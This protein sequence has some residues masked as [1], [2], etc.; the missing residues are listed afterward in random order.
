MLISV[1]SKYFRFHCKY[2]AVLLYNYYTETH[3]TI[4]PSAV[5]FHCLTEK[6]WY[7]SGGEINL[8][9]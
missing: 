9:R 8:P 1:F 3:L 4:I 6:N 5:F 7:M 2:V